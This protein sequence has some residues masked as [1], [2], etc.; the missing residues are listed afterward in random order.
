MKTLLLL[1]LIIPGLV[2]GGKG[3][4]ESKT[5]VPG[6]MKLNKLFGAEV[7]NDYN[8]WDDVDSEVAMRLKLPPESRTTTQSSFRNY[9]MT[10]VDVLDS[11]PFCFS[12]YGKNGLPSMISIIF[13]NKGDVDKYYSTVKPDGK[14]LNV[15]GVND[16]KK[17]IDSEAK[18]IEKKLTS[19]LGKPK[20]DF[21]GQG[22]SDTREK[23][24]RWDIKSHSIL[25]ASP[26]C[27]YAS[28]RII[29]T[30]VANARG[31]VEKVS[32]DELRETIKGN[33]KK[34]DNGD[35]VIK[36]IPMVN[37]G[38]KGYCAPATWSRYLSYLDIPADMYLLAMAGST[39]VGGG[40]SQGALVD[41]VEAL[42]KKYNRR[43][44]TIKKKP[45]AKYIKNYINK[46]I[47][48][49]WTLIVNDN[50]YREISKRTLERKKVE[51]WTTWK[52]QLKPYRKKAKN[53]RLNR[54]NGHICIMMGYNT[55]TKE[56]AISDSYGK[57]FEERWITEEEAE[58]IGGGYFWIISW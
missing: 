54:N 22:S 47:P 6:W 24:K 43:I 16:R 55:K 13:A 32:D 28:I 19:L 45:L 44:K 49:M 12:L 53:I 1:F 8:L 46:G 36:E 7:W 25:L 48:L 2:F 50:H 37:Q 35:V 11:H 3:S 51:D 18:K 38:A 40:T 31:A 17:W 29:P 30:K 9:K 34:R 4:S 42:V 15:R 27:E 41:S 14:I 52:E 58:A 23:V 33:V 20:T 21:F 10:N 56:V 57:G 5:K 26:K 39:G